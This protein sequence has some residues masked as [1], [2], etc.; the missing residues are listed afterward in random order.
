MKEIVV[1]DGS[2]KARVTLWRSS[3]EYEAR[4]GDHVNVTNLVVNNFRGQV[5]LSGTGL[6]RV[7]VFF[8]S[9]LLI[10]HPLQRSGGYIGFGFVGPSH[11]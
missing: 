7:E 2:G 10:I 4:V 3:T 9:L 11:F 8:N 1:E 6:T 5:S